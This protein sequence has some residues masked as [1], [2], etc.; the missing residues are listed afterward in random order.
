MISKQIYRLKKYRH[1]YW[2]H[3][4]HPSV[5]R[6]QMVQRCSLKLCCF[7]VAWWHKF[8]I[9]LSDVIVRFR[10]KIMWFFMPLSHKCKWFTLRNFITTGW[11][12]CSTV[13]RWYMTHTHT[14]THTQYRSC[15][16]NFEPACVEWHSA[17]WR[18]YTVRP[19]SFET[20]PQKLKLVAQLL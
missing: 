12:T 17:I 18:T 16:I 14:H 4:A 11:Y 13:T 5:S 19:I 7:V 2:N 10:I 6:L 1:V 20:I 9:T 8:W 15:P 3:H